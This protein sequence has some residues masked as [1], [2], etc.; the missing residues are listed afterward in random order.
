MKKIFKSSYA[1]S[2]TLRLLDSEIIKSRGLDFYAILQI[3]I[4]LIPKK[5]LFKFRLAYN[6]RI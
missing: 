4:T 2:G 6:S 5:P 3:L 1:A